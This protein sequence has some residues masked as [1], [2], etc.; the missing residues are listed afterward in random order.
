MKK[1]K[2]KNIYNYQAEKPLALLLLGSLLSQVGFSL[3]EIRR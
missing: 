3:I 1:Y 2:V